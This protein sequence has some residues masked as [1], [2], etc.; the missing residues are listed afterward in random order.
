M[1]PKQIVLW[2][3]LPALTFLVGMKF[4]TQFRH[5]EIYVMRQSPMPASLSNALHMTEH[6]I[7]PV[8]MIETPYATAEEKILSM[9]EIRGI[10]S[11]LT[12]HTT[13]PVVID[14]LTITS[15]NGVLARRSTKR[16]L[17]EYQLVKSDGEW[18]IRNAN[19]TQVFVYRPE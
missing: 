10:R 6:G 8:V 19:R 13:M 5:I 9:S 18:T 3:I 17:T 14:S 11:R 16:M 12:W 15:T 4:Y 1:K 2:I 7:D